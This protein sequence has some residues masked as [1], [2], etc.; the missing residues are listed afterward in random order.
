MAL[1]LGQA[2]CVERELVR[3]KRHLQA[4]GRAHRPPGSDLAQV[5]RA[6]PPAQRFDRCNLVRILARGFYAG[7]VLDEARLIAGQGLFL[8]FKGSS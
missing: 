7:V 2:H 5:Q 1:S 3:L 6:Q 8:F 4:T